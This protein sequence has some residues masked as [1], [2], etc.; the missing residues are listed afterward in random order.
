M[1][2]AIQDK[3]NKSAILNVFQNLKVKAPVLKR[4]EIFL[5]EDQE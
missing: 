4:F 2:H 1:I 3:R 5:E